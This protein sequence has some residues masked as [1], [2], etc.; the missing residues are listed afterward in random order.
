[1]DEM[2]VVE[3]WVRGVGTLG[4]LLRAP[5]DLNRVLVGGMLLNTGS[6]PRILKT[7]QNDPEG[8]VLLTQKPLLDETSFDLKKLFTL[9]EGT[10]GHEV[11]KFYFQKNLSPDVFQKPPPL[12]NPEAVYLVMRLRQS[13]DIWHVLTDYD[14]DPVGEVLLQAF[15]FGQLGIP[16]AFII[17]SLGSLRFARTSEK[18]PRR[19]F[20]AYQR[21][22]EAA[23]LAC[24][25]WEQHWNTPLDELKAKFRLSLS[26]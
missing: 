16:S 3:R 18:L 22:K 21:G 11:A 2:S 7:F 5:N 12:K 20:A 4:G 6:F 1:M 17:S 8:Q 25:Y 15:T 23:P 19:T 13:H 14:T 26:H 24:V 10:L 9:P